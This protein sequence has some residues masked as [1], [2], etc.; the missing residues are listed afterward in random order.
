MNE[1]RLLLDL[2][3]KAPQPE[4][5]R[6]TGLR[7]IA[8]T[9]WG[10]MSQAYSPS[11]MSYDLRQLRLKGLIARVEGSHRYILTAYG[12]KVALNS[13]SVFLMPPALAGDDSR[14]SPRS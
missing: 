11:Q 3:T 8:Q 2:C 13:S 4:W 7:P 14:R 1:L 10:V 6:H 12:R 9:L 5:L